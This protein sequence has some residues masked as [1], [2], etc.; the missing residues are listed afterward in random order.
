LH[1]CPELILHD[2]VGWITGTPTVHFGP[3][4]FGGFV[5]ADVEDVTNLVD[6]GLL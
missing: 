3:A 1:V 2:L 4:P 5:L 6:G